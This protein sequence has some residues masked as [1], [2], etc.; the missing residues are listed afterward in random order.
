MRALWY[1]V[2]FG[3][4]PNMKRIIPAIFIAVA[5]LLACFLLV[6]RLFVQDT[7]VQRARVVTPIVNNEDAD[8]EK[9]TSAYADNYRESSFITLAQDET[10]LSTVTIDIDGDSYDD[11]VN[12][13]KTSRSQYITLVVALYNPELAKYERAA[14]LATTI[15]QG[16]TFA[17]TAMDVIGNHHAALLY[18]GVA[19]SGHSVLRIYLGSRDA[20]GEFDI[21]V[22][23]DFDTEGTVFI[24][25]LDRD[26]TYELSLAKGV[27]FPVWV[28]TSETVSGASR[29]DQIQT[30]YRWNEKERKYTLAQQTRVAGSSIAAAELAKIQDGT[31]ETF[32]RFLDGLWYKTENTRDIRY[33]FFDSTAHEIIFEYGDSEE[34]YSWLNSNLRRGGMYFT[35]VNTSIENLQRRFDISLVGLDEIRIRLQDDVRMLINETNL[36][37]GS[38]KKLAT[39]AT[40]QSAQDTG[41]SRLAEI[42]AARWKSADG[43]EVTFADGSYTAKNGAAEDAGRYML[44]TISDTPIL[45]FRTETKTPYFKETYAFDYQKVVTEETTG[46]RTRTKVTD[47]KRTLI[48]RHVVTSPDGFYQSEE[49]P[50]V[51]TRIDE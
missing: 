1:C 17:C 35:A 48:L 8:A 45:Q 18:E 32:S 12:V 39:K 46:R 5:A 44:L 33:I 50:L 49:K 34:V 16:R 9:N 21:S 42:A 22:I 24:Q 6:R 36:W 7:V 26:E 41:A 15:T 51:L 43:F 4:L 37:D 38:Y 30:E 14:N 29:T 19:S 23:G 10:L 28:Y 11:Q 2:F 25:Q 20:H 3:I 47:D 13:V 27:S 40:N 31:V